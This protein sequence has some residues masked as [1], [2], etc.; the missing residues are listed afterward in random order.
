M[1][2][3][4]SQDTHKVD[5]FK[6]CKPGDLIMVS[7]AFKGTWENAQGTFTT[8]R[9]NS[10]V[11]GNTGGKMPRGSGGAD[12]KEV[13]RPDFRWVDKKSQVFPAEK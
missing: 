4:M 8:P 3:Q 2:L 11:P 1:V 7:E 9:D 5:I 6:D 10:A 13:K 12:L